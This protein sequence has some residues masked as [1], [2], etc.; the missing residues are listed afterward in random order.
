MAWEHFDV[1]F[2]LYDRIILRQEVKENRPT[3]S[4]GRPV[5]QLRPAMAGIFHRSLEF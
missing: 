3:P 2:I 4:F 5:K 1:K